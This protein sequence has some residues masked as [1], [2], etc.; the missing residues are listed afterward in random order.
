VVPLLCGQAVAPAARKV[1]VS[2]EPPPALTIRGGALRD[3]VTGAAD[4]LAGKR[5]AI[6][7]VGETQSRPVT[8]SLQHPEQTVRFS[9]LDKFP[10]P[11]P[12][13]TIRLLN[14]NTGQV[15]EKKRVPM[16]LLV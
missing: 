4:L 8:L 1:E 2:L 6:V 12:K 14:A 15:L 13:T 7:K 5:P 9:W 11:P 10:G 3:R 16:N